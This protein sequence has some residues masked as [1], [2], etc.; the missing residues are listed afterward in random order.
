[1]SRLIIAFLILFIF[2]AIL[3]EGTATVHVTPLQWGIR[4]ADQ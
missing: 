3:V 4:S 1:M 2:A